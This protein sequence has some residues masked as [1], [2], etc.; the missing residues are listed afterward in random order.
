MIGQNPSHCSGFSVLKRKYLSCFFVLIY[1]SLL[2]SLLLTNSTDPHAVTTR[3]IPNTTV[4]RWTTSLTPLHTSMTS[5]NSYLKVNHAERITW[6]AL[7]WFRSLRANLKLLFRNKLWRCE[8]NREHIRGIFIFFLKPTN[9]MFFALQFQLAGL[10]PSSPLPT[11]WA[12]L[13]PGAIWSTCSPTS[14][15]KASLPLLKCTT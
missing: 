13:G 3:I 9:R 5:G 7:D 2:C 15:R 4:T 11:V 8:E 1:I 12:G 10:R 14:P 6:F